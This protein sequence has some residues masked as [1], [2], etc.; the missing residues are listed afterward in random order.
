MS[1]FPGSSLFSSPKR[2]ELPP[3]PPPT[4]TRDDPAIAQ[5]A[6]EKARRIQAQKRGLAATILTGSR[7]DLDLGTSEATESGRAK[8]LG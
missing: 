4:P 6:R 5:A 8:L 3:A 7:G 1:I 2:P